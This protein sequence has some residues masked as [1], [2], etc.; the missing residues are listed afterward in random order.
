MRKEE[1]LNYF[2]QGDFGMSVQKSLLLGVYK[3]NHKD[4]KGLFAVIHIKVKE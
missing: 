3:P 2:H 4:F 1:D